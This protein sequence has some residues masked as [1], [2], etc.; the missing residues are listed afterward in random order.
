MPRKQACISR[1]LCLCFAL[2]LEFFPVTSHLA[3]LA[4]SYMFFK[5]DLKSPLLLVAN[6]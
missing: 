6:L 5:L 3:H 1:S 2:S 4:H